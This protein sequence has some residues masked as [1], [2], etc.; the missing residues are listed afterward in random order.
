MTKGASASVTRCHCA[1]L[2]GGPRGRT[3]ARWCGTICRERASCKLPSMRAPMIWC[4]A[5]TYRAANTV[6]TFRLCADCGDER[7]RGE[8]ARS[9]GGKSGDGP[10]LFSC[11]GARRDRCGA[12]EGRCAT[13]LPTVREILRDARPAERCLVAA[14]LATVV[15]DS[16]A[17]CRCAPSLYR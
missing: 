2:P 5:A 4:A 8:R 16:F 3:S 1:G 11:A 10:L 15:P 9:V 14:A 17:V 6:R 12:Q 13:A 7:S